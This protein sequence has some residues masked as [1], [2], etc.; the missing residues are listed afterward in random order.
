MSREGSSFAEFSDLGSVLVRRSNLLYMPRFLVRDTALAI[1]NFCSQMK[2]RLMS[3]AFTW[4]SH[5]R[6]HRI[7]ITI[8]PTSFSTFA[9]LIMRETFF[10]RMQSASVRHVLTSRLPGID[11]NQCPRWHVSTYWGANTVASAM[12]R[13]GIGA[14]FKVWKGHLSRSCSFLLGWP[15]YILRPQ[16]LDHIHSFHGERA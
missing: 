3:D 11:S 16:P 15:D 13:L 1:G 5:G 14:R 4:W 8:T 6:T 2:R 7:N 9:I 10:R 12:I